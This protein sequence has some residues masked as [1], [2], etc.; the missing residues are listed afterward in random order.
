MMPSVRSVPPH[1]RACPGPLDGKDSQKCQSIGTAT[2]SA[3]H[4]RSPAGVQ[5]SKCF[6]QAGI[7]NCTVRLSEGRVLVTVQRQGGFAGQAAVA[8]LTASGSAESGL[9]FLPASGKLSWDPFRVVLPTLS[10][11]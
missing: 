3:A 8:Y 7:M 10:C 4:Y 11:I 1:L 2:F 6:E 5:S 9:D